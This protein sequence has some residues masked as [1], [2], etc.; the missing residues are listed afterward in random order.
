MNYLDKLKNNK[1]LVSD[2]DN[3]C[4]MPM[5]KEKNIYFLVDG[6]GSMMVGN[7]LDKALYSAYVTTRGAQNRH[8][9]KLSVITMLFGCHGTNPIVCTSKTSIGRVQNFFNKV[10]DKGLGARSFLDREIDAITYMMA[11]QEP[12]QDTELVILTDGDL[13]ETDRIQNRLL[14][15]TKLYPNLNINI[16][17]ISDKTNKYINRCDIKELVQGLEK[18]GIDVNFQT[19]DSTTSLIHG[20]QNLLV[21]EAK[22]EPKL[23]SVQAALAK[24]KADFNALSQKISKLEKQL[25]KNTS[26]KPSAKFGL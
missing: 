21:L 25:N 16:S 23:D 20:I 8:D 5:K 6:S 14:G 7:V 17:V 26:K 19:V 13:F 11:V 9:K 1:N 24:I 12:N 2:I 18:E 10:V 3:I 15:L 4:N 22:K